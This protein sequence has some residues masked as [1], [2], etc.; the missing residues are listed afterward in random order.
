MNTR[1]HRHLYSKRTHSYCANCGWV[2]RLLNNRMLLSCTFC[3]KPNQFN[4]NIVSSLQNGPKPLATRPIQQHPHE[5]QRQPQLTDD[6]LKQQLVRQVFRIPL[7]NSGRPQ[8]QHVK[9]S[10]ATH[11]GLSQ[12]NFEP[13]QQ[14]A[15]HSHNV[16][17]EHHRQ[18]AQPSRGTYAEGD[19]PISQEQTT[20]VE[21]LKRIN[22][23]R[24]QQV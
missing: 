1:M 13:Q 21:H 19:S 22:Y 15:G 11:S 16:Y 24:Y 9:S 18:G 3:R 2:Q 17:K 10:G 8:P 7:S 14:Y 20:A 6:Q 23:N 4:F 5:Y 12:F